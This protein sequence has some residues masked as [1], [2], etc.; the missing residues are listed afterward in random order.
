MAAGGRR[1]AD[2]AR[3]RR[4]RRPPLLPDG[5]GRD[6]PRDHQLRRRTAAARAPGRR[7]DPAVL[8][9]QPVLVDLVHRRPSGDPRRH[10]PR[11]ARPAMPQSPADLP[12]QRS[13]AG[14]G[15][16]PDDHLVGDGDR[17]VASRHHPRPALGQRGWCR[18]SCRG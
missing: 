13:H 5:P 14:L 18:W 10:R 2:R 1:G 16:A 6:R 4:L 3:G 9:G 8:R 11:A 17:L 7:P 12:G 15:A